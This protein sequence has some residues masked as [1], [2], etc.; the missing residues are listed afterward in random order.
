MTEPERRAAELR[1][2]LAWLSHQREIL[3]R[4]GGRLD[5]AVEKAAAGRNPE[6]V[7]ATALHLQHYYTAIED[8]LV[9]IAEQLDG[10]VPSDEV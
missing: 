5:R 10:T 1:T 7:A 2:L 8:A 4:V 3:E 6:A 9:R